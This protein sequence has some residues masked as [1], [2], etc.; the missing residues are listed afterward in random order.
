VQMKK[1]HSGAVISRNAQ[2][3]SLYMHSIRGMTDMLYIC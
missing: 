3:L 2:T 1:W